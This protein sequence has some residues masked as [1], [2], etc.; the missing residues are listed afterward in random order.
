MAVEIKHNAGDEVYWLSSKGF[1][2]GWIKR[3]YYSEEKGRDVEHKYFLTCKGNAN[4]YMGD[5]VKPNLIFT[6][7]KQML[8]YYSNQYEK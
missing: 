1:V 2:K 8:E 6:S 3:I 7:Y 4:E 5:E